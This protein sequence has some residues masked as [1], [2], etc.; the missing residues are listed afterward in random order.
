LFPYF[1]I[2]KI[3]HP[4]TKKKQI[5]SAST[6]TT[7]FPLQVLAAQELGYS[8]V[9]VHNN[10]SGGAKREQMHGEKGGLH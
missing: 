1:F 8:A 9:I 4:L 10:K 2:C 6:F 7:K 5:Y 3:F